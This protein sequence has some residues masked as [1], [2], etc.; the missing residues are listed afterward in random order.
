MPN[1]QIKFGNITDHEYDQ[2]YQMMKI[3]RNDH[4]Y[5]HLQHVVG[6]VLL[7]QML[8]VPF[9]N[10]MNSKLLMFGSHRKP[11]LKSHQAFFNIAHSYDLVVV[12]MSHQDI[13]IDLEKIRPFGFTKI[14]RAFSKKEIEY[15]SQLSKKDQSY[16]TL[17]LWTIKEGVLKL[18]GLGLP[19]HPKTVEVDLSDF[20]HAYRNGLTYKINDLKLDPAYVG[21]VV[22]VM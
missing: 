17:K 5:N 13:G 16:Y 6:R 10:L 18:L 4:K 21:T 12:A 19:G 2:Y 15:L 3:D 7:S 8:D 14:R 20:K 1:V 11:Y 22:E 9:Q